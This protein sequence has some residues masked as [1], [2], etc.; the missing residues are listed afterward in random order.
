MRLGGCARACV[1]VHVRACVRVCAGVLSGQGGCVPGLLQP[2]QGGCEEQHAGEM[3]GA[4]CDAVH[5][6]EGVPGYTLPRVG[7]GTQ[8][9][10][11][12]VLRVVCMLWGDGSMWFAVILFALG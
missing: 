2:L 11:C 10:G 4:N 3:C 6:T 9:P 8:T 1:L 5:Y 12:V 7:P